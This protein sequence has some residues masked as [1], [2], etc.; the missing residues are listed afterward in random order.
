MKMCTNSPNAA[1]KGMVAMA[2]WTH[3]YATLKR[4]SCTKHKDGACITPRGR[5]E[6]QDLDSLQRH[7]G[8]IIATT[9]ALSIARLF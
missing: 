9:L 4:T 8:M 7:R 1:Y 5:P 2:G 3:A 6:S